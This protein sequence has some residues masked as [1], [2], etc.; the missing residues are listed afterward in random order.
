MK[1][2]GIIGIKDGW[3][4]RLIYEK[5]REKT[6]ESALFD[7]NDCVL[8]LDHD[9]VICEGQDLSAYDAL[10]LKK[11][12]KDY[13]PDYLDRLE[14]LRIL[15]VR[16]VRIFSDPD[17]VIRMLDRLSCTVTLRQGR[18]PMPPTV[19]TEN[20]KEAV[21]AV[22]DFGAAVFKPLYTSKAKGMMVIK[23]GDPEF[24][25][26]VYEYASHYRFM[27][28]Q[29]ML[30]IREKDLGVCFLGG[31]YIGTYARKKN[32]DSWNTTTREG[33]KYEKH[34][35]SEKIISLAQ[36]AQDL[37]G[38]SFTCVDI[39]ESEEGIFVFEVSAFGGFRGLL[40]G[41]G[42]DAASMYADYVIKEIS[43]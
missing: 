28:I 39:A 17:V 1:K 40:E 36:K 18:I 5:V 34:E 27:Y 3:S 22:Q 6:G 21:K 32:P 26:K 31:R 15:K 30:N 33:G 8:E 38:L 16:G 4:S 2:I 10:I 13:S 14:M 29:K 42:I 11:I 19:V 43:K 41:C 24:T 12:G 7:M 35:P 20:V 9:T 25:E 37:F 23:S